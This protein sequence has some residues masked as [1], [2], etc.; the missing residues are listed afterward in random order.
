MGKRG[1]THVSK[2]ADRRKSFKPDAAL[3]RNI[4]DILRGTASNDAATIHTQP[5]VAVSVVPSRARVPLES[6]SAA[7]SSN[8]P[9]VPERPEAPGVVNRV[10]ASL[11]DAVG[12]AA[13]AASKST[14]L[15]TFELEKSAKSARSTKASHW[16]TWVHL[17]TAWFG[18]SVEPL[19]LTAY[20]I[21]C[22]ASMFKAG[23]YCSFPNYMSIAKAEHIAAF[24][25]HLVPW[26][27]ELT[28][29]VRG[30]SRSVLRGLGSARQSHPLDIQRVHQ[31]ALDSSPIVANGPISPAHFATLGIFFLTRE[32]EISCA[33]FCDIR[34]DMKLQEITWTLPVSKSD[35]RALGTSRT[36]GCV[37][38]GDRTMPCPFHSACEHQSNM[39]AL[40]ARIG[41]QLSAL[42]LFPTSSGAEVTKGD[43]ICTINRLVT[44]YGSPTTDAQKRNLYGGHSLR[45]GGAVALSG[46]GL[47]SVRIEG[48]ARWHSPMLLHYAKLAPLRTLTQEYRRKAQEA[49][50]LQGTHHLE[51]RLAALEKILAR[52]TD[53][54]DNA[55]ADE[56]DI[57]HSTRSSDLYVQKFRLVQMAPVSRPRSRQRDRHYRVQMA[58][59]TS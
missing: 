24:D 49:D 59:Y 28:T 7:S 3:A 16:R 6:G 48:L 29:S 47:D 25:S 32:V 45:T 27:E 46:L 52:V 39:V 14:A 43:A 19:P 58:V 41:K 17:H 30:A 44:L 53:R 1:R 13:S 55:E 23:K 38:Q 42:P 37:C 18:R 4:Q 22:V 2:E 36:W 5:P 50:I 56:L 31:L 10:R 21:A 8:A 9:Y 35:Q 51:G 12:A 40:S 26:S 11:Q 54:L 33:A 34:I 20:K 15:A 57:S